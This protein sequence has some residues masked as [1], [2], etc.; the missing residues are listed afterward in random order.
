VSPS[1]PEPLRGGH[2]LSGFDCGDDSLNLWLLRHAR[3]ADQ[4]GTSRTFVTAAD[5]QVVGFYALAAGQVQPEDATER[6]L[7][8]QPSARPIP[9]VLIARL[10]VDRRYQTRGLGRSLLQNA[11]LRCADVSKEIGFR[12]VVVHAVDETARS[13]Y[14]RFGFQPSPTDPLHLIL[15]MKDLRK[16]LAESA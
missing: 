7:K 5:G 11:L 14:L 15:L 2:V 8:G 16:L 4:H 12:A 10:A 9:V 13:F 6:L 1:R 3:A